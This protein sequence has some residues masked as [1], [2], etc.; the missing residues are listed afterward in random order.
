MLQ[1]KDIPKL[2]EQFFSRFFHLMVFRKSLDI[3]T[4]GYVTQKVSG[5]YQ[6]IYGNFRDIIL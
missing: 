1:A 6:K 2:F 5:Y 3:I 4:N